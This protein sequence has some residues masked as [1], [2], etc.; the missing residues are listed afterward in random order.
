MKLIK[1]EVCIYPSGALQAPLVRTGSITASLFLVLF[2]FLF[3]CHV[4]VFLLSP[5]YR[6]SSSLVKKTTKKTYFFLSALLTVASPLSAHRGRQ[7][8]TQKTF[9]TVLYPFLFSKKK[10]KVSFFTLFSVNFKVWKRNEHVE[11][12]S[13]SENTDWG[14]CPYCY[15]IPAM[16]FITS[17][18][19][20][21]ISC[22]Y[23]CEWKL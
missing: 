19:L 13:P 4:F 21:Y 10:K 8:V 7:S 22:I 17:L 12:S 6:W 20:L 16:Q 11:N 23:I 3:F 14:V 15:T 18:C 1:R 2:H 5:T 9:E